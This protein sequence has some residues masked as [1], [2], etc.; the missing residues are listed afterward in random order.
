MNTL[1]SRNK[2]INLSHFIQIASIAT[3][4]LIMFGSTG[5][6]ASLYDELDSVNQEMEAAK[7]RLNEIRA[8]KKTLTNEI[9]AFDQQIYV[10]QT[11]I[12]STQKQIEVINFEIQNTNEQITKAEI[13]LKLQ[14]EIM[15]EYLRVM[16]MEGQTSTVELI[17]KSNSFSEFVDQSEYLDTMQQ[18]VQETAEKI[19]ALKEE[20]NVKKQELEVKK[21]KTEQLKSEQ[22]AQRAEVDNKKMAKNQIL[23]ITK[24]N[25]KEYQSI[26][27]KLKSEHDSI[28]SQIR[29]SLDTEVSYGDVK[30]G[31]IIGTM[32]N[33]GYSTGCHLHF[34]IWNTSQQHIN[35]ANYLNNG[36][37]K[38][39]AAGTYLT[40]PYGYSSAYFS[41]I[42]HS[43]IDYADGC[44][45]TPIRATA[46]GRIIKRVSGRPNTYPWS[47]EYGNYVII[48]HTNGMYSL[49]G[50]L[51]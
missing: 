22:V 12:N 8:E 9:T 50:H 4:V 2:K 44:A 41:G 25:E 32:G 26:Y 3:L 31:D 13:D 39:P 18:K 24:G 14:K 37:F 49:Y 21:A 7:A 5:A 20:L 36:Y 19:V 29:L 46:D 10:I 42:F 35:P 30:A 45:S 51:R 6:K 15:S 16:Y 47:Y 17:V 34:E 38:Q 40:A 33:S 23:A 28:Q 43:G 27:S 11:Q 48:M 1:K